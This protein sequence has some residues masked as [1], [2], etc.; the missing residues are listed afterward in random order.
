[1]STPTGQYEQAFELSER[2]G[3]AACH[4]A[5]RNGPLAGVLRALQGGWIS[6]HC[7]DSALGSDPSDGSEPSASRRY[8]L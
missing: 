1:M 8:T 4:S 6:R 3:G 2:E 7:G 5:R